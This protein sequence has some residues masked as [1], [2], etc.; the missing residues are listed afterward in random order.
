MGVDLTA[1]RTVLVVHGVQ[2][3]TNKNQNQ[4]KSIETLLKKVAPVLADVSMTE[5]YRYEDENDAAPAVRAS[6]LLFDL[7]GQVSTVF[8]G[9]AFLAKKVIDLVGDVV[10]NLEDGATAALIRNRLKAKILQRY[11]QRQPLYLVAHS[12]GSVYAFD[13]VNELM[14]EH[15]LFMRDNMETWPVQGLMTL[16]SP[17]GL[18][19]FK[20]NRVHKMGPGGEFFPWHNIWDRTDP[21][22]SGNV[23]GKPLQSYVIEDRFKSHDTPSGWTISDTTVD[24]GK[25]WLA[26]HVAYWKQDRVGEALGNMLIG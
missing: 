7:L 10:I 24:T 18:Q 5:M 15:G 2:T 26:S 4:H 12:L 20:R 17:L 25:V 8:K 9:K 16:G 11:E 14:A 1:K 19:L 3:G 22:V 6:K 13:V 21:V 23:F